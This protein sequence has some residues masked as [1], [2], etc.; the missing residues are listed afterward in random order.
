MS[1][2]SWTPVLGIDLGTSTCLACVIKDGR[3]IFIKPDRAY[4]PRDYSGSMDNAGNAM[5]SAFAWVEGKP[6]TGDRALEFLGDSDH[7]GDVVTEIKRHMLADRL[8]PL[9]SGGRSLSPSQIAG[10]FVQVLRRAAEYQFDLPDGAITRAV[11][12]VPASFGTREVKATKEACVA[13][14]LNEDHI[15]PIDEPVAAAYS[16]NLHRQPGSRLV[17]VVDLGGG[18]FDVT[19]LRLGLDVGPSGFEELGRD[20]EQYLGGLDW[21]R[22]IARSAVWSA[23]KKDLEIARRPAWKALGDDRTPAEK[24]SL[25]LDPRSSKDPVK[26]RAFF[27]AHNLL[28]QN[29]ERSKKVFYDQF[30]TSGQFAPESLERL[31]INFELKPHTYSYYATIAAEDHIDDARGLVNNCIAVCD[32]MFHDVSKSTGKTVEWADLDEIYLAGGGSRMATIRHAFTR[33]WREARKKRTPGI[34]DPQVRM[35]D[36]PQGAVAEGAAW[37]AEDVRQGRN[38]NHVRKKRYP[39]EVGLMM[40]GADG[41]RRLKTLVARHSVIP[42]PKPPELICKPRPPQGKWDGRIDIEVFEVETR[43]DPKATPKPILLDT[44]TL[45]QPNSQDPISEKVV[46][47]ATST[48]DGILNLKIR[49]GND[50]HGQVV[51]DPNAPRRPSGESNG[52]ASGTDSP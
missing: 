25:I 33:T 39:R 31:D 48:P 24:I 34:A 44:L 49:W 22:E 5:P 4:Y 10:Y 21:D 41:T 23:L 12:T 1:N 50:S 6:Y 15:I 18:T 14:G 35:A 36:D 52:H 27:V 13:G 37:C 2:P 8:R 28:F 47:S 38:V 9:Q 16:L 26:D 17:M 46:I 19:L 7:V 3:P 51:L 32:R 43:I 11:V 29:A 45:A 20:G 30:Y 42:F 40:T